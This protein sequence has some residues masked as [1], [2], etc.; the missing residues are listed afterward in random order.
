MGSKPDCREFTRSEVNTRMEVRLPS[1]IVLEGCSRNVSLSGVL[2][3]TERS[4]PVG[5]SVRA[6]L[7]L[8]HG[9]NE[10]RIAAE[11]FVVRV[12][13]CGVAIE[14]TKISPESL[15]QLRHLV[16]DAADD[17]EQVER[18]YQARVKSKRKKKD[19]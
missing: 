11:G 8:H 19:A 2:F 1:G 12:T 18:E 13:D 3:A 15:E 16:K 6:T 10:H 14:F 17:A 5:N 7:L 4:L 9:H